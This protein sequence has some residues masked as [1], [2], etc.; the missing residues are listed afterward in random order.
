MTW[1]EWERLKAETAAGRQDGLRLDRADDGPA[2]GPG[3][4]GARSDLVAHQD[5]L[6]AVG[7]DAFVLHDRLSKQVDIAGAGTDR[8]GAGSSMQAAQA[9]KRDNFAMG[10]ALATTV[11]FWSSQLKALLQAC[12]HISHHLDHSK[13]SHAKDDAWVAAD[14]R[15]RGGLPVPTSRL[16]EYFK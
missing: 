16:S 2:P 4:G 8:D 1:S 9:L 5:D 10:T 15:N 13:A 7:H 6:G 12:A 3:G 14:L 11:T